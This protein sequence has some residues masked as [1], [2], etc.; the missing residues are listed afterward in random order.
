MNSGSRPL[1]AVW[2]MIGSSLSFALMGAAVKAATTDFP[3][4]ISLFFRSIAGI[5]PL[6]IL[7]L[8]TQGSLRSSRHPLLFRRSLLGFMAMCL[9]FL[10]IEKLPL[11]TA[12]VLNQSSPVFTV[13]FSALILKEHK[14]LHVLPFAL[15]AFVG[16]AILVG[17]DLSTSGL[18]AA[19]TLVSAVLSALAYVTVKQL[20]STESSAI[21]VFYFSVWGTLFAVVTIAAAFVF[22]WGG[23]DMPS[24]FAH[25]SNPWTLTVLTCVGLFGVLGQLL[26]TASYARARASMVSPFSFFNPMFSYIIGIVAFSEH[27]TLHGILGG[28]LVIVA[29]GAVPLLGVFGHGRGGAG[30]KAS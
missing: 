25:L 30:V 16:V 9:F 15:V 27:V 28:L 1:T 24:V 23:L 5:V 21:I 4:L 8:A 7:V 13:V 20:S 22:G 14:A 3:F 10:G 29:S 26:M 6:G 18:W 17:P 11:S 2:L 19:L 12:V